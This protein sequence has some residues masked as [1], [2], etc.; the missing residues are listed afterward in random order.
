V[1][2]DRPASGAAGAHVQLAGRD[3]AANLARIRVINEDGTT[4]WAPADAAT[5]EDSV[6]RDVHLGAFLDYQFGMPTLHTP[7]RLVGA[8]VLHSVPS[9]AELQ[10]YAA[11]SCR[12]AR[13]VW[14]ASIPWYVTASG[15]LGLGAGPIPPVCGTAPLTLVNLSASDLVSL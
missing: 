1:R 8:L 4:V 2:L 13:E 5:V 15:L 11:A 3:L 9:D 12:D 14:G 6:P 7:I 10:A